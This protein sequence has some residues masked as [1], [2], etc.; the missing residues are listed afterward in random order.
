MRRAT[1]SRKA[2]AVLG[3]LGITFSLLLALLADAAPLR[4]NL[5]SALC[6]ARGAPAKPAG[7]TSPLPQ[8][9]RG[10]AAHHCLLCLG[11]ADHATVPP[12]AV[13]SVP[14]PTGA[15]V[16]RPFL[17]RAPVYPVLIHDRAPRGPPLPA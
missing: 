3:L 2:A 7:D 16:Q 17:P 6:T 9:P 10:I 14:A 5:P 8:P 4:G 11:L 13:T 1:T 12:A 15:A